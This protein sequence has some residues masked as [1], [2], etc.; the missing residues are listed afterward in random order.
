LSQVYALMA[1]KIGGAGAVPGGDRFERPMQMASVADGVR[2]VDVPASAAANGS[3]SNTGVTMLA[4]A[5]R[6]SGLNLLRPDPKH[7]M[8]AYRLIAASLG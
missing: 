7:A 4:M 3:G 2:L 8:L 1:R 5:G 6:Q